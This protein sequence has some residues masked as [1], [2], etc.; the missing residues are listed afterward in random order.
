[1]KLTYFIYLQ[2]TIRRLI[3][4]F[5][6]I[7]ADAN[8]Q[9][10]TLNLICFATKKSPYLGP[11][12]PYQKLQISLFEPKKISHVWL[13]MLHLWM[14]YGPDHTRKTC[15]DI[16]GKHVH[17]AGPEHVS[18]C[19]IHSLRSCSLVHIP[20][21]SC[22]QVEVQVPVDRYEVSSTGLWSCSSAHSQSRFYAFTGPPC[23]NGSIMHA[24]AI[25]NAM[26][27]HMP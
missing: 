8:K 9:F 19:P 4:H 16:C 27:Y 15:S 26:E 25:P 12:S 22:S 6:V 18:K 21:R 24:Y 11:Q 3:K 14:G 20:W 1:M 10:L 5:T 7:Y 17:S 13:W 23:V 2:L